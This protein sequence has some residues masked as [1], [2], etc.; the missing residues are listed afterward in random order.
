[1]PSNH[2]PHRPERFSAG[3]DLAVGSYHV[4]P[5]PEAFSVGQAPIEDA[6][7]ICRTVGL[8]RWYPL[9]R[10]DNPAWRTWP[11]RAAAQAQLD[12]HPDE[13]RDYPFWGR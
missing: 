9:T 1:M 3:A 13:L 4:M 10:K 6:F 8:R 7:T 12:D 5:A 11:T 2:L